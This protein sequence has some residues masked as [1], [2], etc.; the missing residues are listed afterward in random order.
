VGD[1]GARPA[2]AP[3]P[4]DQLPQLHGNLPGT[5]LRATGA[6]GQ[7]DRLSGPG[8]PLAYRP[9]ADPEAAATRR[10]GCLCSTTR[11]T[12]SAR[13]WGVVRAFL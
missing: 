2:L 3:Q 8:H 13:L 6:V 10:P 4:L 12:V 5:V 11:R 9:L 1:L 7:P